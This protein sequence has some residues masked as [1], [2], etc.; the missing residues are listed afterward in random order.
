MESAGTLRRPLA[1]AG[2]S[3]SLK[4]WD[5]ACRILA[6]LPGGYALAAFSGICL[7]VWLPGLRVERAMTGMLTGLLIWPVAFMASF[8]VP[9]G[10]KML[11]GTVIALLALMGLAALRGWR[12]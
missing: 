12:P 5:L 3:L 11:G 1:T 6:A 10:R 8:A 2:K 4:R 9:D 7:A